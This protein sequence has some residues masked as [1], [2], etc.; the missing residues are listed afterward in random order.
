MKRH[1]YKLGYTVTKLHL[2]RS[3]L[4]APAPRRSAHRKKRP[5][6]PLAADPEVEG[7]AALP[8]LYGSDGFGDTA[9]APRLAR[10]LLAE[11]DRKKARRERFFPLIPELIEAPQEIW[12][13]FAR[14]VVTGRVWLR[15]RHVRLVS[16]DKTRVIGLVGDLDGGVW[17]GM[18][19]LTGSGVSAVRAL[20]S[21]LRVFR[22]G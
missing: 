19:F 8:A 13:G 18:T 9:G 4:V 20:R 12:V 1:E 11:P 2:H 14:S 15:R 3:G 10:H 16:V 17:S 6:R 21:G 7:P 5:R 22:D